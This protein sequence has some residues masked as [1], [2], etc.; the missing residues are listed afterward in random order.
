TVRIAERLDEGAGAGGGR[1]HS[2]IPTGRGRLIS[3]IGDADGD[4]HASPFTQGIGDDRFERVTESE[5]V[6]GDVKGA[7]G[8]ADES[9]QTCRDGDGG[10]LTLGEEG[11]DDG[12]EGAS[13]G[14]KGAGHGRLHFLWVVCR[15]A[16]GGVCGRPTGGRLS[17]LEA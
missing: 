16:A 3:V 10:L 2:D 17:L 13:L 15:W 8:T 14:V 7:L 5:V 11:G 1:V 6:D 12:V 9:C 4:T